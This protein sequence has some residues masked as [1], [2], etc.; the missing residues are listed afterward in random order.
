MGQLLS[1]QPQHAKQL[2]APAAPV[3]E[4]AAGAAAR[5]DST[6]KH[7]QH[8]VPP[9]RLAAHGEH[10]QGLRAGAAQQPGHL[11]ERCSSKG[12]AGSA[13]CVISHQ[14][15]VHRRSASQGCAGRAALRLR[16]VSVQHAQRPGCPP[17]QLAAASPAQPL[18]NTSCEHLLHALDSGP[19]P[20]PPG[21]CQTLLTDINCLHSPVLGTLRSSA[22]AATKR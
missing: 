15:G 22:G 11:E 18:A 2:A 21:P 13:G 1:H 4:S 5:R 19:L 7:A 14:R 17:A 3:E 20:P 8:A 12:P 9:T 10:E 16:C 6:H